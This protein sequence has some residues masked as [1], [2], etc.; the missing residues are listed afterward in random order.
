MLLA[1]GH[2]HETSVA[3]L[4]VLVDTN[5]VHLPVAIL[6]TRIFFLDVL[7]LIVV[8]FVVVVVIIC[9]VFFLHVVIVILVT[10]S[11]MTYSDCLLYTSDAA[12]E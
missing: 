1:N 12:D 5:R 4:S 2:I 8:T 6:Q 3:E 7:I 11:D 10:F 9:S